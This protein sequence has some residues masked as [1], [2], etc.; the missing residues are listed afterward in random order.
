MFTVH[1]KLGVKFSSTKQYLIFTAYLILLFIILLLTPVGLTL[2]ESTD[3]HPVYTDFY[4]AYIMII[5]SI[6]FVITLYFSVQIY[7]SF[8]NE[9]LRRRWKYFGFGITGLYVFAYST[10]I[11]YK[12]LSGVI[13]LIM[14]LIDFVL[15][16]LSSFFV[17]YGA[18]KEI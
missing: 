14:S 2:N 8:Q 3:W 4:F 17:Y 10:L 9:D 5:L 6:P 16:I 18:I 11:I 15:I 12:M 13:V 7:K 1:L